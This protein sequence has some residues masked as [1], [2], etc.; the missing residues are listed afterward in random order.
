MKTPKP[1]EDA[2]PLKVP[3]IDA[4]NPI[5]RE[6]ID[7]YRKSRNTLRVKQML[8]QSSRASGGLFD[9]LYVTRVEDPARSS[10]YSVQSHGSAPKLIDT[11]QGLVDEANLIGA[12]TAAESVYIFV[13]GPSPHKDIRAL[14]LS[15]RNLK[16]SVQTPL[17]VAKE[18]LTLA[19]GSAELG[20]STYDLTSAIAGQATLSGLRAAGKTEDGYHQGYVHLTTRLG[21]IEMSIFAKSRA[22]LE[23]FYRILL[24]LFSKPENYGSLSILAVIQEARWQL[25]HE[26]GITLAEVDRDIGVNIAN[27]QVA[28]F[29]DIDDAPSFVMVIALA[30]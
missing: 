20:F 13:D 16:R 11:A 10:L 9:I 19:M 4:A 8:E 6:F 25:A 18:P 5:D 30:P 3:K 12:R 29:F 21:T 26:Q 14:E 24:R 15:L 28:V 23:N 27:S 22:M 1:V 17:V 7:I 2:T